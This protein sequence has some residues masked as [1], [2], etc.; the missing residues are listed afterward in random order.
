M[1]LPL[2]IT[3]RHMDA[4]P[5]L[6]ARIREFAARLEKFSAQIISCHVIVEPTPQHRR[7]GGPHEFHIDITLPDEKIAIRHAHPGDP[8]HEDAYVA[9]RDAFHAAR[10]KLE[11]YE[12]KR[13]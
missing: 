3:F 1:K 10:R 6:E 13:R 11:D 2:Q 12:R 7:H 5:A 8:A 9:L 4:S